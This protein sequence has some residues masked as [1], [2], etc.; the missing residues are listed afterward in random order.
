MILGVDPGTRRVGLALAD[1]E[2]RFAHPLEVC[3]AD[4]AIE[5]IKEVVGEVGATK[6]VVG[7]P[8]TLR[9]SAGPAAQ[10]LIGFLDRLRNAVDVEVDVYDE[11]LTTI[12][13]ERGMRDAGTAAGR[14]KEL[15]DAVAAQVMLQGYV[16]TH[17]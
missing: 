6:I 1:P 7:R 17:L 3:E 15:R 16:D 14:R 5:R 9:G 13:A 8:V 12:V 2:T 11:R 10:A 4:G